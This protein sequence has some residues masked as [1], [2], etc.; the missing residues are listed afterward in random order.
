MTRGT[1]HAEVVVY[2]TR[3]CGY[4]MRARELLAARGIDFQEYAVDSDRE[5]RRE[6]ETLSGRRT[7]PQIFIDGLSIG[8][9]DALH[10]LDTTGKLD[11]LLF[12]KGTGQP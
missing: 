7:V 2:S 9:Y 1:L 11:R 5:K 8:G 4:C 10:A 12:R 6:M 3:L